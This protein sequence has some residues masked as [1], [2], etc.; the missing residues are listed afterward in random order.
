M[1]SKEYFSH[2]IFIK[3]HQKTSKTLQFFIKIALEK[4][5]RFIRKKQ[6]KSIRKKEKEIKTIKH[7]FLLLS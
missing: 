7:L 6:K 2:N 5:K 3:K 1:V 4:R